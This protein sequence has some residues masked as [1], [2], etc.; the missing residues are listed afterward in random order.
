MA[1]PVYTISE[2]DYKI[3][4][5]TVSVYPETVTPVDFPSPGDDQSAPGD[6]IGTTRTEKLI[7][8]A[9]FSYPKTGAYY[10]GGV[11]VELETISTTEF[12]AD[13][14]VT[15]FTESYSGTP[16]TWDE[17]KAIID[18]A[19][20]VNISNYLVDKHERALN[21]TCLADYNKLDEISKVY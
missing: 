21:R 4:R 12:D 1:T 9:D 20:Q 11:S 7:A 19:I 5:V 16:K 6:Y 8:H 10:T 17:I 3:E 2:N 13:G 14:N 18:P 15:A